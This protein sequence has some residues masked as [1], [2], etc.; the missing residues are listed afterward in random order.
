MPRFQRLRHGHLWGHYSSYQRYQEMGR[1]HWQGDN[2]LG[3][4]LDNEVISFIH[5][6][7]YLGNIY[8]VLTVYLGL[9]QGL[10]IKVWKRKQTNKNNPVSFS[11]GP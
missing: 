4:V 8:C 7:I 11:H 9:S 6:F 2:I 5:T 3:W 10:R 1:E